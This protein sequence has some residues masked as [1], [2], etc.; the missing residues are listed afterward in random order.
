MSFQEL[1]LIFG[2]VRGFIGSR[3]VGLY[4]TLG[5]QN[6]RE[7]RM[8]TRSSFSRWFFQFGFFQAQVNTPETDAVIKGLDSVLLSDVSPEVGLLPDVTPMVGLLPDATP[9]VD[10]FGDSVLE[11]VLEICASEPATP[12]IQPPAGLRVTR[13]EKVNFP[14]LEILS[15]PKPVARATRNVRS[16][17]IAKAKRA[18]RRRQRQRAEFARCYRAWLLA[19]VMPGIQAAYSGCWNCD[20]GHF[21]SKCAL[22]LRFFCFR[23]GL[24]NISVRDCPKCKLLWRRQGAWVP[25][26]SRHVPW[27]MNLAQFAGFRH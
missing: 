1:F 22:P 14:V 2:V 23:C 9:E 3:G 20:G 10:S 18:W 15:P 5:C 24:R 7:T 17:R 12:D 25:D 13:V 4:F 27:H 21:Y 16:G 11:D 19:N 6:F 26:L 8:R